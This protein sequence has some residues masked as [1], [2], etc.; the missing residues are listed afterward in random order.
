MGE[1]LADEDFETNRAKFVTKK[2]VVAR[3]RRVL[4]SVQ[5]VEGKKRALGQL[6]NA[7]SFRVFRDGDGGLLLSSDN[8]KSDLFAAAIAARY[9]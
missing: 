6:V 5:D 1:I 8:N 9:R 4:I 2:Y 7:L 3:I